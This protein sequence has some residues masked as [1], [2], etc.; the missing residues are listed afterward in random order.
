MPGFAADNASVMMGSMGGLKA[1]LFEKVSHLFV[2]GC[3][4]YFLSLHL[5]AACQKH[6]K[7]IEELCRDIQVSRICEC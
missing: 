7:S 3:I 6:P 1:K 5:S 4:C 2:M